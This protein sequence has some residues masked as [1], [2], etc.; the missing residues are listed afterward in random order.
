MT[1]PI[2]LYIGS[3]EASLRAEK[4]LISSVERNCSGEID[5]VVMRAGDLNWRRWGM[6]PSHPNHS[7]F[8]CG[9]KMWMNRYSCFRFAV[10]EL[11][12]FQ[13]RAIY[14]DV[15]TIV[16]ADLRELLAI[17]PS[18]KAWVP[19]YAFNT[20]VSVINCDQFDWDWWVSIEWMKSSDWCVEDYVA[21]L[22]RN[23]QIGMGPWVDW[24]CIDGKGY[25]DQT[26]LIHY[27]NQLKKIWKPWPDRFDYKDDL[28]EID[29]VWLEYDKAI[30]SR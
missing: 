15:D 8:D 20:A 19:A 10:P 23:N 13:G 16:L 17:A 3:D 21:H 26:R 2:K 5:L 1:E 25:N 28:R 27:S 11:Q 18:N 24:N 6:Q 12:G 29:H 14:L 22:A 7:A 4:A 30:Q 9:M